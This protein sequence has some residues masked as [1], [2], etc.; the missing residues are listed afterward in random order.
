MCGRYRRDVPWDVLRR[1]LALFRPEAA[2]NLEPELDIRPTQP[3]WVARASPVDGARE[4]ARMRWGLIPYWHRGP[5]KG[6]KLTTFNAKA[7]T[8]ASAATFKGAFQRRRCLVP[9]S[10]WDE[11][12]GPK[13]SKT[14]WTFTPR[15]GGFLTFAG[16]WDRCATEDSGEVESFTIVTQ[17]AGAPLNGYH[18]RAPVVIAPADREAWLDLAA[19]VPPLLGPESVDGYAV[20]PAVTPA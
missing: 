5:V 11:W 8:V 14:R 1:E 2:P 9:A 18:D 16:V 6:F 15:D 7:E 4:L 19:D 20:E 12:T 17:P 10:G 3:Q 13:G